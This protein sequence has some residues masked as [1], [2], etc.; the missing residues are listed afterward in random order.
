[1][2]NFQTKKIALKNKKKIKKFQ[3]SVENNFS[4]QALWE[5]HKIREFRAIKY[6]LTNYAYL[7]LLTK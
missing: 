5:L 4:N 6:V 1:L 7:S 2:N 3:I